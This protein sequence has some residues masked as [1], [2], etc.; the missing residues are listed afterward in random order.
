MDATDLT[1]FFSFFLPDLFSTFWSPSLSNAP[2]LYQW[3]LDLLS[4]VLAQHHF[5]TGRPPP[6]RFRGHILAGLFVEQ[7]LSDLCPQRR[8][9]ELKRRVGCWR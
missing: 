5:S 8:T 9:Q 4:G 7:G 3:I 6:A 2:E 1:F